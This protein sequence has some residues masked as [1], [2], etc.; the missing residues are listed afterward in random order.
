MHVLKQ[1]VRFI[2]IPLLINATVFSMFSLVIFQH[3]SYMI[4]I[5]SEAVLIL[6]LSFEK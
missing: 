6:I 1:R 3:I 5:I 4:Y 2:E